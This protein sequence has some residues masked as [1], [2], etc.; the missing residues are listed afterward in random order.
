[1][2]IDRYIAR[3]LGEL[4]QMKDLRSDAEKELLQAERLHDPERVKQIRNQIEHLDSQIREASEAVRF[5][6]GL[7]NRH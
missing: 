3:K 1:M 5:I 6:G 7:S 4:Q 2:E